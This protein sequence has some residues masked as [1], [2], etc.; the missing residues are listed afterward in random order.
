MTDPVQ[1]IAS[2]AANAAAQN[3]IAANANASTNQ[4]ISSDF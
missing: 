3:A 1:S 4:V 2:A